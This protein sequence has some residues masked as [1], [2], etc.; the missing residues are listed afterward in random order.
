RAISR[1]TPTPLDLLVGYDASGLSICSRLCQPAV[2]IVVVRLGVK[3]SLLKRNMRRCGR[4]QC[5]ED[6]LGGG[7]VLR[8]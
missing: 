1:K 7:D 3:G 8:R 6:S 4:A 5:L 2:E